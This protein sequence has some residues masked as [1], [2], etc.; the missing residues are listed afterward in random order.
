MKTIREQFIFHK[1]DIP[2]VRLITIRSDNGTPFLD[3]AQ[4]F[5]SD[6]LFLQLPIF[7]SKNIKEY[8]Y[9][10]QN[11][12][13]LQK[14]LEILGFNLPYNPKFDESL[15]LSFQNNQKVQDL[16]IFLFLYNCLAFITLSDNTRKIEEYRL[17]F[18]IMNS[19]VS[20]LFHIFYCD[21]FRELLT[22]FLSEY[23]VDIDPTILH[24]ILHQIIANDSFNSSFSKELETIVFNTTLTKNNALVETLLSIIVKLF[25]DKKPV[26]HFS[27][28]SNLILFLTESLC[29][30]ST[31]AL[32]ILAYS[33][34]MEPTNP[35]IIER[36][37]WL[38]NLVIAYLS[39]LPPMYNPQVLFSP[40][41][42]N[43]IKEISSDEQQQDIS[44]NTSPEELINAQSNII[45]ICCHGLNALSAHL[46]IF[47]TLSE[48][49]ELDVFIHSVCNSESHIDST[50]YS[51]DFVVVITSLLS[52]LANSTS[53]SPLI[54]FLIKSKVFDPTFSIYSENGIDPMISKI[55]NSIFNVI[56]E[57]NSTYFYQFLQNSACHPLLLAEH[58]MRLSYKYGNSFFA[59]TNILIS[60]LKSIN[61]LNDKF[62]VTAKN[63]LLSVFISLLDD[64]KI[65]F[66]CFENEEFC[67]NLI[68]LFLETSTTEIATKLFVKCVSKFQSLPESTI[69]FISSILDKSTT[70]ISLT[71]V[72]ISLIKAL[73][74]TISNK[75]SLGVSISPVFD[76]TLQFLSSCTDNETLEMTMNICALITQS[77][78]S[79]EVNSERY[80]RILDIIYKIEKDEPSDFTL[81]SFLNQLNQSTNTAIDQMFLIQTSDVIPIIL[82]AF[83]K[84]K[85]L[86]T[87]IDLFQKL[88]LFS[89]KN[90]TA[91]H[92]GDLS[93]ILLKSLIGPFIYKERHLSF[94]IADD[95]VDNI[96][97][98]ISTVV[99][100]RSSI[101]I[102]D[103][104]LRLI[105]PENGGFLN[106]SEKAAMALYQL[107]TP[108]D[109]SSV[110]Q[111]TSEIPV[112]TIKNVDGESLINGFAFSFQAKIDL[113]TIMSASYPLFVY[114]R[115]S[116]NESRSLELFQQQ[117]TFMAV[118]DTSQ[119]Q[120]RTPLSIQPPSNKWICITIFFYVEGNKTIVYFK[121]GNTLSDDFKFRQL[122]FN[123]EID[124]SIGMTK[125]GSID[126]SEISPISMNHFALFLPPYDDEWFDTFSGNGFIEMSRFEQIAFHD[127]SSNSRFNSRAKRNN[128]GITSLLPVH[129]KLSDFINIFEN[130][131]NQSNLFKELCLNSA[132]LCTNSMNKPISGAAYCSLPQDSINLDTIEKFIFIPTK[133]LN[134]FMTSNAISFQ[135]YLTNLSLLFSVILTTEFRKEYFLLS[136]VSKLIQSTNT[137]NID[138][139]IELIENVI[140]NVWYWCSNTEQSSFKKNLR[141][142]T[143]F[144][145]QF[146]FPD[147]IQ[148]N[149]FSEFLIQ[150]HLLWN[151][152]TE[153]YQWI[154][155][156][157]FR[158]LEL[159][160]ITSQDVETIV[161]IILLNYNKCDIALFNADDPIQKA[162]PN[163]QQRT[164]EMIN[165]IQFLGQLSSQR[166]IVFQKKILLALTEIAY[167]SP[168]AVVTELI[169]LLKISAGENLHDC[170]L[171]IAL[172][173]NDLNVFDLIYD[174]LDIVCIQVIKSKSIDKLLEFINTK[175]NS[176]KNN[177]LWWLWLTLTALIT[178]DI[179]VFEIIIDN[180]SIDN[181]L[182]FQSFYSLIISTIAVLRKTN[183]FPNIHFL[184]NYFI[185]SILEFSLKNIATIPKSNLLS[186]SVISFFAMFHKLQFDGHRSNF[187]MK[188]ISETYPNLAKYK[189]P[190]KLNFELNFDNLKTILDVN[191]EKCNFTFWL[192]HTKPLNFKNIQS[193]KTIIDMLIKHDYDHFLLKP[194]SE[195]MTNILTYHKIDNKLSDKLF[196]LILNNLDNDEVLNE[197]KRQ[198]KSFWFA[199]R[200]LLTNI[201]HNFVYEDSFFSQVSIEM[202]RFIAFS[203]IHKMYKETE[204]SHSNISISRFIRFPIVFPTHL[205]IAN[206]MHKMSLPTS[207][208]LTVSSS[209][210][211]S[212]SLLNPKNEPHENFRRSRTDSSAS[213]VGPLTSI[214]YVSFKCHIITIN[215]PLPATYLV[216]KD[217]FRLIQIGR[218]LIRIPF[219]II[220]CMNTFRSG[221][222]EIFVSA[223]N[224]Y[225]L[226]M[227]ANDISRY[228]Q[229]LKQK[230]PY[231]SSFKLPSSRSILI[232][233]PILM[234]TDEIS[235]R[236]LDMY[237]SGYSTVYDT[238]LAL[239]FVKG[240][241]FNDS[242]YFPVFPIIW[243][244]KFQS[245]HSTEIDNR[246]YSKWIK[247]FDRTNFTEF[248]HSMPP[249]TFPQLYNMNSPFLSEFKDI[250]QAE[251]IKKIYQSRKLM[252]K[253]AIRNRIHKWIQ[254]Q[255]NI[256]FSV[257]KRKT[258]NIETAISTFIG[259]KL[260]L[261]KESTSESLLIKTIKPIEFCNFFHG[262]KDAF[263]VLVKKT[264][265]NSPVLTFKVFVFSKSGDMFDLKRATSSSTSSGENTT[266]NAFFF[267]PDHDYLFNVLR[268]FTVIIDRT[269]NIGY[270]IYNATDI[271]QFA[272]AN[273]ITNITS[274][275]NMLIS[276]INDHLISVC[277]IERFP[278]KID[279]KNRNVIQFTQSS[280][281]GNEEQ[282]FGHVIACET[283]K[284][285]I[286]TTS[287]DLRIMVYQTDDLKLKVLSIDDS[288]FISVTQ[289]D[290]P[291]DNLIVTELNGL[292]MCKSHTEI[293]MFTLTGNLIKKTQFHSDFLILTPWSSFK[294]VD[295]V[296][297]VDNK[298]D[299]GLFEALYP[300][301][302][303]ILLRGMNNIA[304]MKVN[305]KKSSLIIV[306]KSGEITFIPISSKILFE[307]C[308]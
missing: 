137:K 140:L 71:N 157:R 178:Q 308:L 13:R 32:T 256:Q 82:A 51:I 213:L 154:D 203:D 126:S 119:Q 229:S 85:R 287:K 125:N 220:K 286:F 223:F 120:T 191:I 221:C 54:P 64:S 244:G 46:K 249:F 162:L 65:S 303:K 33:S 34:Q 242:S 86:S 233:F 261:K 183:S 263:S 248:I 12:D 305:H 254:H 264:A 40:N 108:I 123:R 18:S 173:T 273:N 7:P 132:F 3:D 101:L 68:D 177:D 117:D 247:S 112:Y 141:Y 105:S 50:L 27:N 196:P 280:A 212:E 224:S 172:K 69:D 107:F 77:Q 271:T 22:L 153:K 222:I 89:V 37:Q 163:E 218:P 217:E 55:R 181:P 259:E 52:T 58:I 118:Y 144:L 288:V 269:R 204:P 2:L 114:L 53:I 275:D 284:I 121:Y 84:S 278:T 80:N 129:K 185:E 167:N 164:S 236:V 252:E 75:I 219:N 235:S 17:I 90:I 39:K 184:L 88:C 232:P 161:S 16:S 282:L 151:Y 283:T 20:S 96:F 214:D 128:L 304:T 149:L 292:I 301:D 38:P 63:I 169:A 148:T 245:S 210:E 268:H 165:Y 31:N 42:Q 188:M 274:I 267:E 116:D 106:I 208:F 91:C 83:S 300:T 10:I 29:S 124:I 174:S 192:S 291:L 182:V 93:F 175:S 168:L 279:V 73:I 155:T 136:T 67:N 110:F 240:R 100:Y 21:I 239:N 194:M 251:L 199:I 26:I 133:I 215:G 207:S 70:E 8:F 41:M 180:L 294:G 146:S 260:S 281:D 241:S 115:I 78:N 200:S 246:L 255:F 227:S 293:F 15:F 122:V 62:H 24:L 76:K 166:G 142:L 250:S 272:I 94:L 30:L 296:F 160:P 109:E 276:I 295:Y 45:D 25:Q 130:I 156:Y 257:P 205:T 99:S 43:T 201:S 131:D 104:F 97:T 209:F 6:P 189:P 186:V 60:M 87:I 179:K 159:L 81:Q 262:S 266:K 152:S 23:D 9:S 113:A 127:R 211:S 92:L 170:L 190:T 158:I 290:S 307:L 72:S 299:L 14:S 4:D 228:Q 187:L 79:I 111:I 57:I 195:F 231:T 302:R 277:D 306:S 49:S 230:G 36:Y 138:N 5:R 253:R 270:R 145:S 289:L 143:N 47:I 150:S 202:Y 102:D 59:H 35:I 193:L 226:S 139:Q 297:Y 243:D 234:N 48:P 28:F 285:R 74:A 298:G 225:L 1:N 66:L 238:L 134:A 258:S 19:S 171:A 11:E 265:N 198:T 237:L 216:M 206:K 44:F 197:L 135:L 176:I 98:L 95:I 61:M 103:T 56:S 147:S